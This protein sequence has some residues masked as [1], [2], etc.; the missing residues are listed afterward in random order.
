MSDLIHDEKCHVLAEVATYIDMCCSRVRHEGAN[1]H[2]IDRPDVY[3]SSTSGAP[4]D[5]FPLIT[6][7]T[8][9]RLS[10]VLLDL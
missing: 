4:N 2:Q 7:K 8:I 10:R 3:R 9:F 1:L 6:L 5:G